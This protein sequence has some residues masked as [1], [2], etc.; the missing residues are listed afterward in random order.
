VLTSTDGVTWTDRG[1]VTRPNDASGNR[2]EVTLRPVEAQHVKVAFT[3]TFTKSA[4]GVFLD[5]IEI[6]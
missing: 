5:E 4:D 2:Y 6:Y 1:G 3:R